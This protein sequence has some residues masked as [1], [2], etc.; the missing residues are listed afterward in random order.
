MGNNWILLGMMGSGKSTVGKAL[1]AGTGRAFVDS[2]VLIENRFGRRIPEIFRIYSEPTFR[3]HETSVLKSLD[4][5]DA[6]IAT[7]GGVVLREENWRE[8][9]RLGITVFLD[10][11]VEVLGARLE[12]A[13]RKRPLLAQENWLE[14][15]K[16]LLEA[17]RPLYCQA[18]VCVRVGNM[19]LNECVECVRVQAEAALARR[20]AL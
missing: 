6:V 4:V 20:G 16:E 18:D 19:D 12:G 14:R 13:R 9:R 2:D 15:L 7:G 5:S 11:D 10:V 8:M 17:R 1:A 3:A